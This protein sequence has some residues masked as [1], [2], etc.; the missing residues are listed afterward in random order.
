MKNLTIVALIVGAVSLGV[1]LYS[2]AGV[3][4]ENHGT[5]FA[6]AGSTPSDLKFSLRRERTWRAF[7][8]EMEKERKP[9]ADVR[10]SVE[11]REGCNV[12][13]E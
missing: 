11:A 7:F 4:H 3:G 2:T 8:A 5:A 6:A 1:A 9:A 12:V 10:E 13:C